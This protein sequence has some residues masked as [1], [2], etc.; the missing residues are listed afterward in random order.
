MSVFG[1]LGRNGGLQ[2]LATTAVVGRGR[3]RVKLLAGRW[4]GV[5]GWLQ[6]GPVGVSYSSR[7]RYQSLGSIG[8]NPMRVGK[9]LRRSA[10]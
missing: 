1:G 9:G 10:I 6:D 7:S 3:I 8:W 2:G 5:A 4:S